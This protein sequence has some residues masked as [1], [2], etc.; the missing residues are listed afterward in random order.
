MKIYSYVVAR[1]FGF[2]PNPFHGICTL[3]TCKPKIRLKAEIGDWIIGTGSK[4]DEM[5]NKLIYAMRITEKMSIQEY[6][7][8]DRFSCKKPIKNGSLVQMN[9][10][11]IYWR[12]E[13]NNEWQQENSHHSLEDGVINYLNLNRD[14]SG[15][16]VLI[17]DYFFYFG[18][19]AVD[20]P[21]EF[22]P[23]IMKRGQGH[24]KIISEWGNLFVNYLT[25]NFSNG[26]HADPIKFSNFERYKGI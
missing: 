4:K 2:A 7:E 13:I 3:T 17:S 10:D 9:G 24:K 25:N 18:S 8:S 5:N 6:W 15:R 11:N 19:K 26:I 16:Y 23:H 14:L 12:N 22:V 1:D 21:S 20:I